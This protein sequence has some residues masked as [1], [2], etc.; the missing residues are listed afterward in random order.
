MFPP[1]DRPVITDPEVLIAQG[2]MPQV[3][4]LGQPYQKLARAPEGWE[5]FFVDAVQYLND[6]VTRVGGEPFTE[7]HLTL[8]AGKVVYS[9]TDPDQPRDVINRLGLISV[10]DGEGSD[11]TWWLWLD[12]DEHP[13]GALTAMPPTE[14]EDE[15]RTSWLKVAAMPS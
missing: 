3:N 9:T 15:A 5:G 14:D 13:G 10:S 2:E 7:R 12:R 8:Q 1:S 6:T 11:P 4:H